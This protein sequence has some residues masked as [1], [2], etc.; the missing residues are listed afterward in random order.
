MLKLEGMT[1]REKI[2]YTVLLTFGLLLTIVFAVWW[3][4]PSHLSHN[5]HG[6]AHIN[7]YILF[8]VLSYIVWHQIVMELFSW[9]VAAYVK[10]PDHTITPKPNMRVAYLTAFVPG[11]EPYDI[12]EKT[13]IAMVGVDYPHDTWL[14]DEGNDPIAR[15]ICA[16]HGVHHY[17]RNGI[18][19]FNTIDGKFARKTKGGNYN[20]WLHHY[21]KKYDIVAQHDVDFIPTK[22]FLTRTLGYFSDPSVAFVGTPQVYGNLEDSWITRGQQNKHMVFMD[23]FKKGFM[24]MI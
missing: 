13:L 4:N 21:D 6:I 11:S 19:R 7:D 3:F 18:P 16:R 15:A 8:F 1:P 20:S 5:F 12:L 9:Y 2:S 10:H 17:S 22:N 23:R 24:V 14:L